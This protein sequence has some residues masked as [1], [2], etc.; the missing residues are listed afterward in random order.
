MQKINVDSTD[1]QKIK[2]KLVNDNVFANVSAL[3]DFALTKS[4]EDGNAPF[5]IDDIENY[6]ANFPCYQGEFADFDRGTEEER[7]RGIKRLELLEVKAEDR[8]KLQEEINELKNLE[9]EP[10]EIYEWWIVSG[11][12]CD[13]LSKRG[14]CVVKGYNIWGRQCTGQTILLDNV[15]SDI[16]LDMEILSGQKNDWLIKNLV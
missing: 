12:L 11:W 14:E 2:R 6:S 5:S 10:A 3:A 4:H 16:A 15:I 1:N 9:P 8:E 7:D 13:E